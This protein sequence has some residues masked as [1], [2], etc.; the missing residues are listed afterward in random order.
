MD[1]FSAFDEADALHEAKKR[2][3][4]ESEEKAATKSQKT[5]TSSD[6]KVKPTSSISEEQTE[7][8]PS[9]NQPEQKKEDSK[10]EKEEISLDLTKFS[11]AELLARVVIEGGDRRKDCIHEVCIPPNYVKEGKEEGL[12]KPVRVGEPAK[13]YSFVLDP[14]QETAVA[15]L[16][17]NE[18][19]LVSAHT[20]AGKT[21]VAEYAIAKSLKNKQRVIYTS[22][23]K[24]LSN[25][26]YRE[27]QEEFSDVG[28]MTGDVTINPN[29]SC[30]VMTTE[31]LRSMLYR[32]S[33][34]MREVAWVIFD[35]IHYMRD[36]ERGVVWEETIILLPDRVRYVFLSATIPNAREFA[37]WIATL[38]T[39]I[40]HVCYTDYRPTPLQ[41]YIYPSGSD[42]IHLV[43]DE[44]GEFRED[45]F[46]KALSVLSANA[47][48]S[49][50]DAG[51]KKRGKEVPGVYKIVKMIMEKQYDPVIV[52]AF[53]KADCESR[54]LQMAKL[55]LTTEEEKELI[56]SVFTNAIDCLSDEDK[57]LP[58][59]INMLP[60]L[61]RGIG[62][63]H[64]GLL[65]ILKEVTEILFQE[66]LIKCLFATE[67]FAMGLNM[68]AK[69]VVFTSVRKFDGQDFRY[70]SSGEYIQMSGR[71]GR[72]GLDD[73][74]IVIL[75]VDEK[76]EPAVCKSMLKGEADPLNSSFHI[77]YNM[78][79][80]L[81]RLEGVQP[82]YML[83][84]SFYQFQHQRSIPS[85]HQKIAD[86]DS[87]IEKINIKDEKEILEYYMLKN[88][89]ETLKMEVRKTLVQPQ[90]ALPFL[91]PGRLVKVQKGPEDW[92]W[93][94]VVSF[95]KKMENRIDAPPSYVVDILL[96]VAKGSGGSV[97]SKDL[98]PAGDGP[99]EMKVIPIM[100]DLIE[101]FSKIRLSIQKDLRNAAHRST[102]DRHLQE[103]LKRF[104]GEIPL[105]DPLTDM[106]IKSDA[107]SK[108]LRKLEGV[109]SRLLKCAAYAAPDRDERYSQYLQKVQLT[110]VKKSLKKKLRDSE[111]VVMLK[112]LKGMK[113]VLKRLGYTTSEHIIDTKGRVACE[114]NTSDELLVT[115]LIFNGVFNELT[116]SQTTALLSVMMESGGKADE[117]VKLKEELAGPL[118]V[119]HESAKS[120]AQVSRDCRLE[121]DV[122]EYVQKFSGL[123]M[124]DVVHAWTEGASFAAIIK[125]SSVF[126]GNIIRIIRRLEE[127]LRQLSNA[128]KSIGDQ[129]LENKFAECISRIKRDIVFAASLY[130]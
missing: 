8:L 22:P 118:R 117:K 33:E 63:H 105:L 2:K 58:Q 3:R 42:G 26:K 53:S 51:K 50:A 27:L 128:A 16:E 111:N 56:H 106:N 43:V 112:E 12:I 6:A 57:K 35:E 83:K 39:Q 130:L 93:G 97:G 65:P 123:Q 28:L 45:N 115:E 119:L 40:M 24:A 107:F 68:P 109:E 13:T 80:N 88:Q 126:E 9:Q 127:L 21:V 79:L 95:H 66:G 81:L 84:R 75:M 48:V 116:P 87:Q 77:S 85:L 99:G 34:L 52:F 121:V 47:A 55:D 113:R 90:Y 124:M 30:L 73:R 94:V 101:N 54:G 5:V 120:V 96:R 59:I 78:L 74:G 122:E 32:G 70:V 38:H 23:I 76:M 102:C 82:E 4:N 104:K 19:V 69:T 100:L 91:N 103:T 89:A 29:A 25:Q 31:I 44:M 20:S 11:Q 72:R 49:K 114:I 17:R 125:L 60:L 7:N 71:A 1:L 36:K 10:E 67:T 14:F 41:H 61:K 64:G 62:I 18:S 15:C 37:L 46:Q 92:G 98:R 86:M 108:A 129:H 110:E